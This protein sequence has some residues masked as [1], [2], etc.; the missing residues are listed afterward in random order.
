[1]PLQIQNGQTI[2]FIGDSITDCGR[3]EGSPPPPL[4]NGYVK[5]FTDL[6]AIREPQKKITVHNRGI[7]GDRVNSGLTHIPNSGLT[8]RWET[9]VVAL[10]PDWLSVMIGIND[11]ASNITPGVTPVTPEIYER[12]Y[13]ELLQRSREA[14]PRCQFLL[15]E[16]FFMMRPPYTDPKWEQVASLLPDYLATV[17]RLSRK[18]QTRLV[19]THALFQ[20]LVKHHGLERFGGEPVHPNAT[21]HLAIAEAVYAALS[22]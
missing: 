13:D 12:T 18:Y 1:M 9:D 16:S 11:V 20:E 7:N 2:V 21:G 6:A 17:H 15:L 5:F 10:K 22:V 14:L 3:R 4:G 8:N 19:R